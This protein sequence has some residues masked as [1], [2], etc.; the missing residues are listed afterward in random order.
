MKKL[1]LTLA[2]ATCSQPAQPRPL[3]PM[4]PPKPAMPAYG[5]DKPLP[6]PH[7]VKKTLANGLQVWVVPR[8]ACRAST[9]CWP[10]AAPATAPTTLAHAGFANM[11][12]GLLNE[13]T[14]KRELARDRRSGPGH[15]RLGRRRRHAGR[16]HR[17]GQ[18][19]G[20]AGRGR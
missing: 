3:P 5:K 7:I 14:A 6:T 10:Y 4:P 17:L 20:L 9:W 18:R 15:G 1:M 2:I 16:H 11:M 19:R 13:G 8:K 12:A